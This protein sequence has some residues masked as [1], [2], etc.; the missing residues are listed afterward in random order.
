MKKINFLAVLSIL[1]ICVLFV[2]CGKDDSSTTTPA[3]S[4]TI[5]GVQ[6]VPNAT[7]AKSQNGKCKL[8]LSDNKSTVALELSATDKGIYPISSLKSANGLS[9]TASITMDGV[10]YTATGGTVEITD[11]Q[12]STVTGK[13]SFTAKDKAGNTKNVQGGTFS[14]VAVVKVNGLSFPTLGGSISFVKDGVTYIM[15]NIQATGTYPSGV[16]RESNGDTFLQLDFFDGKSSLTF[17]LSRITPNSVSMSSRWTG[18][19]GTYSE[20][21]GGTVSQ[22]SGIVAYVD[23]FFGSTPKVYDNGF[24][25]GNASIVVTSCS[26]NKISGTFSFRL[27]IVDA[28]GFS[29]GKET[30]TITNGVFTDVEYK[31]L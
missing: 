12:N 28:E 31:G 13:Y 10:V 15:Y 2:F 16:N 22:L 1:T 14:N 9:A 21:S 11:N 20:Y 19:T 4:T 6:F 18:E 5:D 30:I 29:S 3:S 8:V 25:G 27:G 23:N 24:S 17:E 26:N 7:T